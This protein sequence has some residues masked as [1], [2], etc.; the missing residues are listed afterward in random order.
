MEQFIAWYCSEPRLALNR[1]VVLR[2]RLHLESVGLA[3]GTIN[4]RLAAVRRLAYEAA[5]SGLLSPELAAGIRRVKG[6]K[7]LG[8]RTGN[9]LTRDQARLLLE[10]ADGDDL[11]CLRD[12]A[13]ISILLGCGLRRAELSALT[14]EDMQIRQG[15]WAIVDLVG[16]GGHIRTVPMPNWV[17]FAVDRWMTEAKVNAGR[18]FRAVSCQVPHLAHKVLMTQRSL[19]SVTQGKRTGL[20]KRAFA[21]R[22]PADHKQAHYR[23]VTRRRQIR[24][25]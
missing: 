18:I 9:W 14:V 3:A 22:S 12:F 13:M 23:Q 20:H 21:L 15:H 11:R 19:T 4:Q 25:G 17:K 6:V 16:K 7:Q 10:K 5:D 2:F 1:A 8:A 24:P